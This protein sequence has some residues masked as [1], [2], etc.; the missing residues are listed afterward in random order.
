MFLVGFRFVNFNY[1]G[2]V[3]VDVFVVVLNF[4]C[5]CGK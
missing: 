1:F 4:M 2:I 5:W 3:V